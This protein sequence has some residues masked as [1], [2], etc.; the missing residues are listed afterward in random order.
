M[1]YINEE[2]ADAFDPETLCILGDAMD[3][4]WRRVKLDHLNGSADGARAVLTQH[5][6]ALAR[7]GERDPQH[8]IDGALMR[9]TL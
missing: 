1:V 7:K 6:F 3:E 9:L 5:I 2:D 4:A 8:L